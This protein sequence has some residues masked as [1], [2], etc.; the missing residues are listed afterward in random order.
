MGK[1][2]YLCVSARQMS[3]LRRTSKAPL[4]IK[5]LDWG[6]LTLIG[7]FAVGCWLDCK[8]LALALALRAGVGTRVLN[9]DSDDA[10]GARIESV[11]SLDGSSLCSPTPAPMS[12][13]GKAGNKNRSS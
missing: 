1:H 3:Y 11:K 2:I 6:D 8:A 7:C 13:R 10:L 9:G 5:A 12:M 4:I